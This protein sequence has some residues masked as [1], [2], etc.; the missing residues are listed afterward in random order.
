MQNRRQLT[1]V[2]FVAGGLYFPGSPAAIQDARTSRSCTVIS[3]ILPGGIACERDPSADHGFGFVVED[4]L[5]KRPIRCF[6][7]GG[8][9]VRQ[10]AP[11]VLDQS[12][13]GASR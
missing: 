6:D 12:G 11:S 10:K 5:Y 13:T 8:K 9:R 2:R 7:G 4:S 3:V 1:A